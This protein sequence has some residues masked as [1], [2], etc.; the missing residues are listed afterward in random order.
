MLR[1]PVFCYCFVVAELTMNSHR[2][3]T[4]VQQHAKICVEVPAHS[5]PKLKA[6]C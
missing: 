1:V 2:V 4:V 5:S 6:F 3:S